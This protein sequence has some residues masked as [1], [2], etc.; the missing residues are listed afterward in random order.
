MELTIGKAAMDTEAL[1]AILK[2]VQAM[3]YE[4]HHD[5]VVSFSELTIP[6]CHVVS[7]PKKDTLDEVYAEVLEG[8][9]TE[10]V[11]LK[12]ARNSSKPANIQVIDNEINNLL[13]D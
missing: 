8:H 9:T 1:H 2:H 11:M 10:D 7:K 3:S 5:I 13:I 4:I 12:F 6:V